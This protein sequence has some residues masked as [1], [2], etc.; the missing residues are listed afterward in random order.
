MIEDIKYFEC[1]STDSTNLEV[2]RQFDKMTDADRTSYGFFVASADFQSAGRGQR[3]NS[4]ESAPGD[5]L[6]FSIL[7]FSHSVSVT[8]QFRLSQ[9]MA[10]AICNSLNQIKN[11][12]KIKWPNDIYYKE[13]KISGTI[14][15]TTWR[16]SMV[17]RCILGVGINVN[18][19]SFKSGAPN[20]VSL[21]QITGKETDRGELLHAVVAGF[22]H[23][24]Q[25]LYQDGEAE[26]ARRYNEK[27]VWKDG[28]HQ[29][30][31]IDGEFCARFVDV[32][33]DGHLVL[34]DENENCRRYMFKE[35][36]HI[37]NN[38]ECV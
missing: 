16:G 3:G 7:F 9:A 12:F 29:Y 1:I 15:E 14:I 24:L 11:G 30:R 20:P 38:M 2:V 27:L 31:D 19:Q 25:A 35:V 10:V 22:D 32:E 5:N 28:V 34:L 13:R 4:W 26:L 8:H 18:Q 33:P 23:E 37:F 17:D 21:W 6:L 36:K